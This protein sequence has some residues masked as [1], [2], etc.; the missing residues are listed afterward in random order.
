[1]KFNYPEMQTS[2]VGGL[3]VYTTPSG[4]HYPSIT[5]VLGNTMPE[6]KSKA[7]KKWQEALGTAEAARKTKEYADSGTAVHLLAERYLNREELVKPEESFNPLDVSKFNALKT[8]L[9]RVTEV[10]GQ[11][12]PLASDLLAVAGRCDLVGVYKNKACIIDFK[13]SARLKSQKQIDDYRL[14]LCAYSVMHNEMFGTNITDGVVLMT[15]DGGFPQEFR[16]DL[17]QYLEPLVARIE[18]FY[19]K[20]EVA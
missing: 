4:V 15:S 7:L 17:T 1:M 11:E 8:L 3:R 13:T 16:M 6:E 20:L 19:Q 10:W 9:N 18:E 14:Q 5:T 12:V 2:N